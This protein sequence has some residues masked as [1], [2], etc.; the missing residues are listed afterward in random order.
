[1][2][3]FLP[4]SICNRLTSRYNWYFKHILFTSTTTP[5]SSLILPEPYNL[6]DI[7]QIQLTIHTTNLINSLNDAGT[8]RTLTKIR[9]KE[10]QMT[11]WLLDDFFSPNTINP[12]KICNN[13]SSIILQ[14]FLRLNININF[15]YTQIFKHTGGKIAIKQIIPFI[16]KV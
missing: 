6:P 11:N 8:L 14:Q 9:L 12:I 5:N 13:L 4:K 1:M 10:L 2:N 7:Y 16:K 3:S 15:T